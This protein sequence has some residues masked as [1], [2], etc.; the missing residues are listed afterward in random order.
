ME[1]KIVVRKRNPEDWFA[2]TC[3]IGP[4]GK[5]ATHVMVVPVGGQVSD[6]NFA[7][8]D[9]HNVEIWSGNC[10]GEEHTGDCR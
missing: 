4:C 8:C 9:D 7:L 3:I 5:P 1:H 2:P 6:H 10:R